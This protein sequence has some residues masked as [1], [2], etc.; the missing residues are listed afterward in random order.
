MPKKRTISILIIFI[1]ILYFLTLVNSTSYFENFK[2][3]HEIY[4]GSSSSCAEVICVDGK[5]V[6][7]Y[8]GKSGE[9]VFI[10]GDSVSVDNIMHEFDASIVFTEQVENGESYYA[11]SKSIRYRKTVKGKVV[12]LQ[13]Y[14]S[15]KGIKIGSPLIYGSF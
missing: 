2:G 6:K 4:L 14:K 15:E 3:T 8:L 7:N 5:K 12:N 1:L 9:A 11:Y 13:I 10:E